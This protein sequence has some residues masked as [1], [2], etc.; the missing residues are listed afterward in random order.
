MEDER[1]GSYGEIELHDGSNE[2]IDDSTSRSNSKRNVAR[3][4]GLDE[5]QERELYGTDERRCEG[6]EI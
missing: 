5:K 1:T 3:I 2:F 4:A 6:D